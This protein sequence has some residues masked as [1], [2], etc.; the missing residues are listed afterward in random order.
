MNEFKGIFENLMLFVGFGKNK[1]CY[2]SPS[3]KRVRATKIF[4]TFNNIPKL[5][6]EI[7]R[8]YYEFIP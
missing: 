7:P 4:E 1:I 8:Y 6:L 3:S 5:D 2:S